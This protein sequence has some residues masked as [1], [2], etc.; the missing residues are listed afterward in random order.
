MSDRSKNPLDALERAQEE[1][2]FHKKDQALVEAMRLKLKREQDADAIKAET[3]ITDD[4][5][6][7]RLAELGVERET[8]PVLHLAPLIQVAW[9]DGEI[10]GAERDLLN[11]AADAT[12]VTGPARKKLDELL[13]ARPSDAWFDAA[14]DFIRHMLAA[15]PDSQATA[16][17]DNLEDLAWRVADAAGGV[18]GLWGRVEDEEKAV[19]RNIAERLGAGHG[20]ATSKLLEKL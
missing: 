12:G 15:L 19:L 18:F 2:Y 3:G 20:E 16:A 4:A 10:Q 11:E 1:T 14:L 8:I 5:L 13:E 7:A 9:A 17:R 6:L